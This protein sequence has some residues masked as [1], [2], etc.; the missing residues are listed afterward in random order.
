MCNEQN[1]NLA[2]LSPS[3]NDLEYC[4]TGAPVLTVVLADAYWTDSQ[5]RLQKFVAAVTGP[6]YLWCDSVWSI[7]Q[8]LK[9]VF[10]AEL[11]VSFFLA[12]SLAYAR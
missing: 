5:Q 3:S 4:T 12:S 7:N 6:A 9:Y 2:V 8:L 1:M 10:A 11:M